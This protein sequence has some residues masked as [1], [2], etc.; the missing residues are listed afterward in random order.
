MQVLSLAYAVLGE[1]DSAV[2]L[3]E[4][5]IMLKP[6]AKDAVYGPSLEEN[7]ALIQ[8]MFGQNSR[9]ISTLTQLLQTPYKS[10]LYNRGPI[11]SAHLRLYPVRTRSAAI[12]A[13]KNRS[14][15]RTEIV[16]PA[17]AAS[18]G[19][20]VASH[21]DTQSAVAPVTFFATA[22]KLLGRNE[23]R[24]VSEQRPKP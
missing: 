23:K 18:P 19:R 7:L 1:E 12:R 5:A 17:V 13:S 2:K 8:A 15:G 22:C 24:S 3:A 14:P 9:A 4:H 10:W 16:P 21:C 11:T 6:R 20:G